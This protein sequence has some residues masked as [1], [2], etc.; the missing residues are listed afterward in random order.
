MN[1]YNLRRI[2]HPWMLSPS[3]KHIDSF[4][5]T[6]TTC[7]VAQIKQPN[8]YTRKRRLDCNINFIFSI[9]ELQKS[10]S[11]NE[12]L[13]T[14]FILLM[15]KTETILYIQCF[16]N[17]DDSPIGFCPLEM[18]FTMFYVCKIEITNVNETSW[19]TSTLIS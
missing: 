14:F 8:C 15:S 19:F 16:L 11:S 13:K 10:Y 9:S 2:L 7:V 1:V 12:T 6:R 4:T 3:Y 17:L 18:I 5:R